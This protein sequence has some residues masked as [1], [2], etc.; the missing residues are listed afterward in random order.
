MGLAMA[1][2]CDTVRTDMATTIDD[3]CVGEGEGEEEEEEDDDD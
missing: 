2:V 1:A 3:D